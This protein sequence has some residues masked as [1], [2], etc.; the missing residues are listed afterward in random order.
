[1]ATK[2]RYLADLAGTKK[3]TFKVGATLA[4][5]ATRL[6]SVTAGDLVGGGAL[7]GDLTLGLANTS[8]VAG[9][10]GSAAISPEIVVD[11]KGRLTSVT[12]RA[13]TPAA[14]GASALGHAHAWSDI[15]SGLPTTL[16]GYGITNGVTTADARLTDSRAPNGTAGGDLSG[17]Y[18]NPALA[19]SGVAAAT[20]G[21]ATLVPQITVDAK[22][23]ITSATTVAISAAPSG[24]AGGHLT[25]TYPNPSVADGVVSNAKLANSSLT[26]TA[27]TGLSG[28][29]AVSLGATVSLS[30]AYGATSVTACRGDDARLSDS[31]A[32]SGAAGGSLT[33]T[34]PNPTI[35]ASAIT[36][37]MVSASAA[38]AWSKISKSGAVPGDVGAA[39]ASHNQAWSTI[40]STPTTVAGYSISD[41]VTTA[42]TV[43]TRYSLQGGG[44]LN[45][46]LTLDL[47]GDV[48]SPGNSQ[49]YGTDGSGTRGWYSLPA[50]SGGAPTGASY[51]V[52]GLDATLTAERVLTAGVGLSF[53]DAGANSTLTVAVAFG[54]TGTTACV[55]NDARLSDS[56]APTGAA[57]GDLGGTY[58][59]PTLQGSAVVT[60]LNAMS[61]ADL[62]MS[63]I[64]FVDGTDATKK[65]SFDVSAITTVT[66]R[67]ATFPNASITVAGINITQT[68]TAAQTF[69]VANAIRSEVAATQDAIVLAGRSGGT[70][71]Y[72]N[73]ITTAALTG[74]RSATLPDASIVVAGSAAALT[75]GRVPF[76]TAGGLLADSDSLSFATRTLT[77]GNGTNAPYFNCNGGAGTVKGLSI[78]SASVDRWICGVGNAAESVADAGSQ[79]VIFAFTDAGG[80]I[81]TP[82]SIVR[83]AGGAITLARPVTC[84]GTVT[85]PNG[86]AAAPGIRTTAYA[87]GLYSVDASNLGFAADGALAMSVAKPNGSTVGG[88]LQL[89]TPTAA[90][91]AI[92]NISL[93]SSYLQLASDPSLSGGGIKLYGPSH[94]TKANVV[95]FLVVG[96]PVATF[97]AAGVLSVATTTDASAIG[98]ASAVF[99][100]GGSFAKS[101]Y[102][103]GTA[104]NFIDI[105]NA[106]GELRINGTKVVA[107]RGAAVADA[108]AGSGTATSGG[109]G[110]VSAAEFNAFITAFNATKDQLNTALARLRSHGLIA[111]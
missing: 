1:M 73:T 87:H 105:A 66:T 91:R 38:I 68:W 37:T 23:R 84:T 106:T 51:L 77:V 13:I 63:A 9:T 49:Y 8:V 55:G 78:K 103:G 64:R 107:A 90:E 11:A 104:G 94:A 42:R 16:A 52:L 30:V 79:F 24:A 32:P 6:V 22:G 100:G 93:N 70:S 95:E 62:K 41:A 72:A 74:N 4:V 99:L 15:A 92:V 12:N 96:S 10:Y 58:P 88:S 53:T 31:R 33:G 29:G 108:A 27:G 2:N 67:V 97:S 76:V 14:I 39:A 17:S 59:N 43:S 110:F 48:A 54:A 111:P 57:G 5:L 71:S 40:T 65:L 21:S 34:Y 75:P 56:R 80:A 46:N 109:Y 69:R 18:P 28:G 81:D 85:V 102:I 98:A 89:R 86:S 44:A 50:P 83:A 3:S 101:L 47:V 35:A 20:Y 82:L 36:D 45:S 61:T 7:S 26:V 19:A 60:R 25:G